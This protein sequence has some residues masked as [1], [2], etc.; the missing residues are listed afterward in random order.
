MYFNPFI[1]NHNIPITFNTT[2][3]PP[4]YN[5]NWGQPHPYYFCNP[6]SAIAYTDISLCVPNT[7]TF[8]GTVSSVSISFTSSVCGTFIYTNGTTAPFT[9]I[10]YIAPSTNAF[11]TKIVKKIP[12]TI[13]LTFNTFTYLSQSYTPTVITLEQSTTN[14]SIPTVLTGTAGGSITLIVIYYYRGSNWT[15]NDIL[16][17][18]N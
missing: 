12:D 5:P 2:R 16:L 15:I 4:T 14:T 18:P 9:S 1:K 10:L 17:Y 8:T 11:S 6:S 7:I 3:G 13:T